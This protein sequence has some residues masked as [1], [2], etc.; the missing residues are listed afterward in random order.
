[1]VLTMHTRKQGERESAVAEALKTE[2]RLVRRPRVF[3]A[4][5]YLYVL[6]FASNEFEVLIVT[7]AWSKYLARKFCTNQV[8]ALAA[9]DPDGDV[10]HYAVRALAAADPQAAAPLV[11]A[12]AVAAA[13]RAGTGSGVRSPPS[14]PPTA[15]SAVGGSGVGPGAAVG[16]GAGAKAG[17]SLS[18]QQAS[19]PGPPPPPPPSPPPAARK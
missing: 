17:E 2:V 6:P 9:T 11:A 19:P 5:S 7:R 4:S 14:R 16:A 18:R 13:S 8:T 12:A 1:M 15:G 10:R 3:V